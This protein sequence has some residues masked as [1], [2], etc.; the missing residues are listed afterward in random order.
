M[1]NEFNVT[2]REPKSRGNNFRNNDID[3]VYDYSYVD[4]IRRHTT[5][6]TSHSSDTRSRSSRSSFRFSG[7]FKRDSV[8][9][10]SLPPGFYSSKPSMRTTSV[11]PVR[12][13]KAPQSSQQIKTVFE[14]SR[15]KSV[16]TQ[17]SSHGSIRPHDPRLKNGSRPMSGSNLTSKR[18][19]SSVRSIPTE[20]STANCNNTEKSLKSILR[21]SKSVYALTPEEYSQAENSNKTKK[22]RHSV[23]FGDVEDPEDYIDFMHSE[24]FRRRYGYRENRDDVKALRIRGDLNKDVI[25]EHDFISST[26]HSSVGFFRSRSVRK[27]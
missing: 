4:E 19:F 25:D 13:I 9:R 7:A 2:F 15:S 17:Q 27:F 22:L 24:K 8:K 18:T 14:Y 26:P 23:S 3:D 21:H 20:S 5:S 6:P 10:K 16:P 1:E 12:N 11:S